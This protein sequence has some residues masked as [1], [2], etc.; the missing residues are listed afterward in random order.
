MCRGLRG[1]KAVA[2]AEATPAPAVGGTETILVAEDDA[3]VRSLTV[4]I[5]RGAGYRV[6][7]ATNGRH[8]LD[9]AAAH[10]GTIELVVTDVMMPEMGGRQLVD[11]L[12]E[13]AIVARAL[14]VSGYTENSIVHQGV[15]EDD[16]EF[17]P[18]PFGP[19]TLLERV[20]VLLSRPL[21]A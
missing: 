21:K 15:L 12:R 7:E 1:A 16:I 9:L 3:R 11:A 8:A 14:F 5:L 4:R 10:R 6:L 13:R 17:L 2:E 19:T 20:R 18:K